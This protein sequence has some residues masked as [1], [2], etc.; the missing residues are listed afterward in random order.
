ML[1]QGRAQ[2]GHLL[3][4]SEFHQGWRR[5]ATGIEDEGAAAGEAAAAGIS[6]GVGTRPAMVARRPVRGPSEGMEPIRPRV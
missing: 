2:A 6:A 5:D 3:P 4:G 1:F